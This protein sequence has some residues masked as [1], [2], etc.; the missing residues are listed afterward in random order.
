MN[1]I[2]EANDIYNRLRSEILSA[3]GKFISSA[4]LLSAAEGLGC[5]MPAFLQSPP[6][7]A[8]FCDAIIRLVTED[9][10][11]PMGRKT[12]LITGLYAKYRV[13]QQAKEKEKDTAIAAD[14]IRTIAPPAVLDH[15][16]KNLQDFHEDRTI[17]AVISEFLRQ[18]RSN[19]VTVNERAYDLFG[20]EKFFQGAGAMRS[21]GETVLR[22]LGLS[23]RDL[24]CKQTLEPFFSFQKKDFHLR[25]ARVVYI[26]ENKDTF[27]SFKQQVMDSPSVIAADML[28]YG[29]GKKIISS[30]RFIEEYDVNHREEIFYYFGDLDAE[31][32]NIYCELVNEYPEYKIVPF[33]EGY[34]AM[35]EIGLSK[36]LRKTPNQQRIR[37]DHI[38]KFAANFHHDLA[39]Q[40]LRYLEA[41]CYIPQ[42]A[43]SA[44]EMKA[45][46]GIRT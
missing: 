37:R 3:R 11:S 33:V 14:I 44:S 46:F 41:G 10:L 38:E 6:G 45:R 12:T 31:G 13:N 16:L 23:F 18:G 39:N 24:G 26:I 17:I 22:R 34:Q 15:Y 25:S 42:E 2:R 28:I 7:R 36:G 43:L 8:V 20:D 27:W 35:M 9:L 21:R 1:E 5:D 30:F 40:L 29:E 4:Q 19:V 32:I